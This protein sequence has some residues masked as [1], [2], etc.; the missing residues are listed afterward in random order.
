MANWFRRIAPLVIVALVLIAASRFFP[1]PEPIVQPIQYNHNIHVEQE[2]MECIDCHRYVEDKPYA[3]I[4]QV[5][6][7]SDC[8][9]GDPIS[10][11]AEEEILLG[12]L[13]N[14]EEI[15]WR[16]IYEVP[17]HVYF[18][19]RRHVTL[20]EIACSTC[21][22]NVAQQVVPVPAPV[23]RLS[24]EWCMGCHRDNQ[25]STDCLTCHR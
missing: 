13:E 20:G 14:D 25:V 12:Q 16:R 1:E 7:C 8:H 21:H 3:T 6:I 22:G 11:S 18:S 2:G 10:E 24:M 4:P 19:H 17:D 5:D 23:N 9:G 15:A